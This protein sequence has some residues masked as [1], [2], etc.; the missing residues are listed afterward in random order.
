MLIKAMLSAPDKGILLENIGA[1]DFVACLPDQM[2]LHFTDIAVA[3]LAQSWPVGTVL[4]TLADDCNSADERGVYILNES[5][6]DPQRRFRRT[7]AADSTITF[8][9]KKSS[10]KSVA[11]ELEISYGHLVDGGQQTVFTTTATSYF[12]HSKMGTLTSS[13]FVTTVSPTVFTETVTNSASA[14][15]VSTSAI[16]SSSAQSV[17]ASTESEAPLSPAAQAILEDLSKGLP[18]P[19]PDGTITLP[20]KKGSDE[21]APPVVAETEPFNTDP[22][23]QAKLQAQMEADHLDTAE[24]LAEDVMNDLGD[25]EESNVSA[26]SPVKLYTS[27]YS[28]TSDADYDSAKPV[29]VITP[30]SKTKRFVPARAMSAPVPRAAVMATDI[31]P[32]ST[33]HSLSKR[34]GWDTFFEVMG[35]DL[36]GE[37]CEICGAM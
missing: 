24:A 25:I 34:D 26:D 36:V 17:P 8:A 29:E 13:I 7:R 10:L 18:A 35:D 28:G 12:T 32:S 16:S 9:V 31:T 3:E 4:V 23:Y 37:I 1:I 11:D 14:T 27:S 2:V 15:P 30:S 21:P 22:A 20:I 5:L 33:R 6:Q 19:G